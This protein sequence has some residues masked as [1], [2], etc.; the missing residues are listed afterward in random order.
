MMKQSWDYGANTSSINYYV[1][2]TSKLLRYR[3][4][5]IEPIYI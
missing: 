3:R 5:K 4:K 2:K 1:L